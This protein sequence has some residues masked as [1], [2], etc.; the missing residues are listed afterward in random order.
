GGRE[1]DGWGKGSEDLSTV[2]P[3]ASRELAEAVRAAGARMLDAPVS[4]SVVTLT[5]GELSVMVGGD[6]ET[7][8]R[9]R[10][11]LEDIGPTVT[12]VGPNRSEEH[13]SEL[14]SLTNLVCRL[15]LEKKKNP[16][17]TKHECRADRKRHEP[18]HRTPEESR[19]RIEPTSKQWRPESGDVP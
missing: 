3:A 18:A 9:V 11:I 8:E 4:G 14:Q 5:E 6:R 16:N 19:R 2:S 17:R 15:L 1:G 12:H 7:F 13:T 10:S